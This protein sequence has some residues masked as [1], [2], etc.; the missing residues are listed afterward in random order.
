MEKSVHA[1]HRKPEL[2]PTAQK[3]DKSSQNPQFSDVNA[4]AGN[5]G[6]L[7]TVSAKKPLE[8]CAKKSDQQKPAILTDFIRFKTLVFRKYA[9]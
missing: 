5:Q 4:I 7:Q 2:F 1:L 8:I 9:F 6:Y 3:P